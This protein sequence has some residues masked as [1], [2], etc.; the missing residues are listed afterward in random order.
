MIEHLHRYLNKLYGFSNFSKSKIKSH[1]L[2]F[3]MPYLNG[4]LHIGHGY[5]LIQGDIKLK[6][7]KLFNKGIVTNYILPFHATGLPILQK[8]ENLQKNNELVE[9]ELSEILNYVNPNLNKDIKKLDVYQWL[10]IFKKY[11]IDSIKTLNCNIDWNKTHVTT[12][13][14]YSSFVN[15]YFHLLDSNNLIYKADHPVIFCKQC[16]IPIG[17]HERK[18]GENVYLQ[19]RDYNIIKY[20]DLDL[21]VLSTSQKSNIIY[22]PKNQEYF[23]VKFK[24]KKFITTKSI[25]DQISELHNLTY[26]KVDLDL[27]LQELDCLSFVDSTKIKNNIKGE[28]QF[29]TF[30]EPVSCRRF[31]SASLKL[32][33]NQ[34]FIRYSDKVWKSNTIKL[35]QNIII[36]PGYKKQLLNRINS[37]QDWVFTR[38]SGIGTKFYK[39]PTK[40]IEPLSDSVIFMFYSSISNLLQSKHYYP[41]EF[42]DYIVFG[43]DS[44]N[45]NYNYPESYKIRENV[46]NWNNT[47]HTHITAKDLISNHIL[48]CC[49]AQ[50]ITNFKLNQFL[51]TGHILISN[52]KLSKSSGTSLPLSPNLKDS[53]TLRVLLSDLTSPGNDGNLNIDT[54]KQYKLGFKQFENQIF[55]LPKISFK[56]YFQI[57]K[58]LDYVFYSQFYQTLSKIKNYS[59]EN[60]FR[61]VFRSTRYNLQNLLKLYIKLQGSNLKLIETILKAQASI[62]GVYSNQ[63]IKSFESI[64][65]TPIQ[66]FVFPNKYTIYNLE[67]LFKISKDVSKFSNN[68][69]FKYLKIITSDKSL[70]YMLSIKNIQNLLSSNN[71]KIYPEYINNLPDEYKYAKLQIIN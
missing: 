54:I 7:Y 49:F 50:S 25:K 14:S 66:Y 31:H 6:L 64:G 8:L 71:F 39:D 29:K 35:I 61:N 68:K 51:I 10:E 46:L 16:N 38:E 26:K 55:R 21:L 57:L 5:L 20:N 59:Q 27:D 32:L 13:I 17:D 11:N 22:K 63:Y 23:E 3:S 67:T 19:I 42:W 2:T 18:L 45:I 41:L 70:Y 37:L 15:W 9:K 52:Q 58:P 34:W 24:N 62:L 43:K 56:K 33:D 40:V 12:D 60:D 69:N 53:G 47:Y 28:L 1:I 4:K 30:V 36:L 48:F 65:I 44:Y